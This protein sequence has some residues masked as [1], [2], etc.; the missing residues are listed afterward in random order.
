MRNL[1]FEVPLQET[2]KEKCATLYS[3]VCLINRNEEKWTITPKHTGYFHR[4]QTK[5][6]RILKTPTSISTLHLGFVWKVLF[7]AGTGSTQAENGSNW[8]LQRS[9][10]VYRFL[11]TSFISALRLLLHLIPF[12]SNLPSDEGNSCSDKDSVSRFLR[13]EIKK[14]KGALSTSQN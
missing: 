5:M 4:H 3:G 10:L 12:S 2:P 11:D 8:P 14:T 13:K 7:Q 1:A 6:A 9:A